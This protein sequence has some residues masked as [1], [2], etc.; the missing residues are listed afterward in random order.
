MLLINLL[1]LFKGKGKNLGLL[2]KQHLSRFLLNFFRARQKE[3]L[4]VAV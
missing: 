3:L 1:E 2:R 4:F